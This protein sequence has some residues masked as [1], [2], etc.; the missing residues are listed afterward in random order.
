VLIED[1]RDAKAKREALETHSRV[2][3]S[4]NE[5]LAAELAVFVE[6]DDSVRQ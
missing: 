4:Q 2:L 3:R 1:L 6:T 5:E